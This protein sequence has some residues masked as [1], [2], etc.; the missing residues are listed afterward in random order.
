MCKDLE[1]KVCLSSSSRSKQAN[2]AQATVKAGV[3]GDEVQ[4]DKGSD[5]IGLVSHRNDSRVSL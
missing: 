5:L 1:A 2:V 4:E 3:L